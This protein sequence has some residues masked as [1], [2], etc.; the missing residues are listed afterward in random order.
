MSAQQQS[1]LYSRLQEVRS[2]RFVDV[3][4]GEVFFRLQSLHDS[5]AQL[6][7]RPKEI[8]RYFPIALF[9]CI[10]TWVRMAVRDL[11]EFNGSYKDNAEKLMHGKKLDF[12]NLTK[13]N[14]KNFTI[15]DIV[16]ASVQISRFEHVM[17]IMDNIL[18]EDFG[19]KI[20]KVQSRVCGETMDKNELPK[21]I[22]NF[23]ETCYWVKK[24]I[25]LR[26][27]FCHETALAE[28]IAISDVQ[29]CMHHTTRFLFAAEETVGIA[30]V[31]E[32]PATDAES[33]EI[34][35]KKKRKARNQ[36]DCVV[37]KILSSIT[38]DKQ[39]QM[40]I[41]ANDAWEKYLSANVK[42]M[43]FKFSEHNRFHVLEGGAENV[44]MEER[45]EY[46]EKMYDTFIRSDN[47][48]TPEL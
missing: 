2:R 21:I 1:H 8:Y 12:A 5:F 45:S 15:G 34:I 10:E 29:Q 40:F 11:I 6:G 43:M 18:G 16:A 20:A 44:L 48:K 9:S 13:L 7:E 42:F 39:K 4:T 46:L 25:H 35:E 36:L 30:I 17:G 3:R 26:H 33:F 32:L 14:S 28:K 31:G 22:L 19:N 23:D 38:S 37:R 47:R 24:T 41:E 27:V